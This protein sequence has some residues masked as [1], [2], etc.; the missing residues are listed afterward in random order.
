MEIKNIKLSSAGQ[1]CLGKLLLYLGI[2]AKEIT[3]MAIHLGLVMMVKNVDFFI[4][5]KNKVR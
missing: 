3:Y 4:E 2:P 1:E 5:D